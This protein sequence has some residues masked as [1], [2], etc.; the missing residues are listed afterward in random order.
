[1]GEHDINRNELGKAAVEL[2]DGI[3]QAHPLSVGGRA[4]AVKWARYRLD[5]R[6]APDRPPW[7]AAVAATIRRHVDNALDI[8]PDAPTA[9][10]DKGRIIGLTRDRAN[11]ATL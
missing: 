11:D 3:N 1:M 10:V 5:L 2:V 4:Y 9:T 8:E 6:D 7:P